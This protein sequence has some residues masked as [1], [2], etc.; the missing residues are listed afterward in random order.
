[1]IIN[2]IFHRK[3]EKR[4]WMLLV[5]EETEIDRYVFC[6]KH[7]TDLK[8]LVINPFKQLDLNNHEVCVHLLL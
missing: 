2:F 8:P 6:I 4:K 3:F 7:L 5:L 1:M